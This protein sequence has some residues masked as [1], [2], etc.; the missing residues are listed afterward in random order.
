MNKSF[1]VNYLARNFQDLKKEL[2]N[3]S[4]RFYGTEFADLSEASINSLMI[5]SVAYVGDILSYYLDYQANESF[6]ATA[7][8]PKNVLNLAKELGYKATPTATTTG[9]IN[10]YMV[11]PNFNNGPDFSKAPR[12]LKGTQISDAS[13]LKRFLLAEDVILDAETVGMSKQPVYV[14]AGVV[15]KWG[16][17][18]KAPVISGKIT[19]KSFSVNGFTPFK[20][21]SLEDALAVEIINVYDSDGNQYYEVPNLTQNIVYKSFYNPTDSTML[22]RKDLRPVIAQRRFVFDLNNGAPQL[23]FGGK[24]YK[25][26][27]DLSINP[28]YEPSK[29]IFNNFN[30]DYPLGNY[31]NPARLLNSDYYGIGPDNTSVT[32]NYRSNAS[33]NNTYTGELTTISNLIYEFAGNITLPEQS[34]ILSS[35]KITNTE[36]IIGENVNLTINEIKDISGIIYQAQNRAVTAKDY[37]ALAYLMPP[38]YGAI[39]R[40]KAERDPN[41]VKNNI[42]LYVVCEQ[43]GET[44]TVLAKANT[45]IK[46][47]IKNWLSEYKMMTDTLDILDAKIINLRI[48]FSVLCDPAFSKAALLALAQNELINKFSTPPEIGQSLNLLDIYRVL[49][50]IDGILDVKDII[51]ENVTGTG[52]S[53][54]RYDV[55]ENK[56]S[57]GYTIYIPR[58]AIYEIRKLKD[59]IIGEAI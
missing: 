59:D 21:I 22:A 19:T 15:K 48:K 20:T 29:F 43:Q 44:N 52:Y 49:S 26:D 28:V 50:A 55:D 6:L 1:K 53:S 3:Y 31:F 34:T 46:E 17:T 18:V 24:Q 54:L 8:E 9:Y 11:L 25:P 32:V 39:K 10:L 13:K 35:I 12:I 47:N 51:V 7:T 41:S 5:D 30:T 56:S 58:N 27:E 33:V 57:D 42:N 16:I 23:I 2:R 40:A 45:K 38:K 4:A 14:D 36:P 37:E